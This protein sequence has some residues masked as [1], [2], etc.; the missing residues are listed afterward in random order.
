MIRV[1]NGLMIT[2]G[3]IYNLYDMFSSQFWIYHYCGSW[4]G[5][6]WNW[7]ILAKLSNF[8]FFENFTLGDT[9]LSAEILMIRVGNGLMITCGI[10]YNLYDMFSSQFWIN[11]YC[12]SW[13]GAVW[14]WAILAKL[15]NLLFFEN[16][17]LGGTYLSAEILM[18]RIGNGLMITYAII[19]NLYDMFS[20][21]FWINHYCG[22]WIGAV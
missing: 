11:H 15:S 10:I 6:V 8:G 17:T 7:E 5:A 1:G 18:I 3:I 20:S 14:N 2:C 13:I 16:F 9:Y 4:I 21:Q 12:G 19:Y 22:S